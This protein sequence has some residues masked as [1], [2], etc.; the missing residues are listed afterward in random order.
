MN[1]DPDISAV[2]SLIAD[3]ARAAILSILMDDISLPAGE[4]AWFAKITP[5]TA[6]FHLAKLIKCNLVSVKKSGR[7]RYYRLSNKNVA[8]AIE[9]LAFIAPPSRV[10]SLRDSIERKAVH[11]ARTCYDHLAGE[12]GVAVTQA[13]TDKNVIQY[14]D[15]SYEVTEMGEAWL[16][17]LKI[18]C[19]QLRKERRLFARACPD[20]SERRP[21]IAGALGAA[22]LQRFLELKW[23]IRISDSRAIRVTESGRKN[24]KEQ[25]GI[26]WK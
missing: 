25:F 24:F 12:L 8:Q 26:E 10:S 5:Q 13:L 21:H 22:I 16:A 1:N 18:D 9:S 14:H 4:L 17:S 2:A 15:E 23:I 19:H 11:H 20:W 3:P 7:H 6:S